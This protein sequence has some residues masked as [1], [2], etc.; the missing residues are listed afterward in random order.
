MVKR[1]QRALNEF[2]KATSRVYRTIDVLNVAGISGLFIACISYF[3]I[4]RLLPLEIDGRASW[5]VGLFFAVWLLTLLHS[6][7]RSMNQAWREQL[8]V[9]PAGIKNCAHAD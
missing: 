8:L 9:L 3:W 1:R 5:E 6:A 7:I 2:G 4:N